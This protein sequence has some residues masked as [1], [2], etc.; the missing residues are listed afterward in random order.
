MTRFFSHVV[1]LLGK[2][3]RAG[4]LLMRG[5]LWLNFLWTLVLLKEYGIFIVGMLKPNNGFKSHETNINA[6]SPLQYSLDCPHLNMTKV[7]K[8]T[9][10]RTHI[11]TLENGITW[12]SPTKSLDRNMAHC[13]THIGGWIH[14]Q[15]L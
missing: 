11:I 12:I 9:M 15:A 2:I 4:V 14:H 3:Q 5:C 13:K 10:I 6:L 7:K 8:D 1:I